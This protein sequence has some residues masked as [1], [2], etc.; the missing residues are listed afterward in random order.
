ML[1]R[2]R[3]QLKVPGSRLEGGELLT[4][5]FRRFRSFCRLFTNFWIDIFSE[6]SVNMNLNAVIAQH[7][8]L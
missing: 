4:S 5:E 3:E 2:I 8:L 7:F 1:Q 6:L